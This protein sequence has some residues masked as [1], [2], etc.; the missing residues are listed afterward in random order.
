MFIVTFFLYCAGVILQRS[1]R[2]VCGVAKKPNPFT[3]P[4]TVAMY[5]CS[6]SRPPKTTPHFYQGFHFF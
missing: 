5:F 3:P 4:Q 6:V 1:N 2:Q